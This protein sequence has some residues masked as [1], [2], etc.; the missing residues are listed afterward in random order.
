[1]RSRKKRQVEETTSSNQTE[2]T[3]DSIKVLESRTDP[4]DLIQVHWVQSR[5]TR[6]KML[7]TMSNSAYVSHFPVLQMGN[8]FEWIIMDFDAKFAAPNILES[9]PEFAATIM[10]FA[11]SY[12]NKSEHLKL[13]LNSPEATSH[14]AVMA[15]KILPL[16]LKTPTKGIKPK[17]NPKKATAKKSAD[18]NPEDKT[19]FS[20]DA[21]E[22]GE[23]QP[24]KKTF[25]ASKPEVALDFIPHYAVILLFFFFRS[26]KDFYQFFVVS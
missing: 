14:A 12:R 25:R 3:G 26:A 17:K 8:G 22:G 4:K 10:K 9:W 11:S 15:I 16:I 18:G 2:D 5:A 6:D 21:V 19:L 23:Q 20:V 13:L 24:P 7:Q 1:M